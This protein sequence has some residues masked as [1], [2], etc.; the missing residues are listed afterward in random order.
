[1]KAEGV[2]NTPYFRA[3][4][5]LGAQLTTEDEVAGVRFSVWAP[6]ANRVELFGDFNDWT[7]GVHDLHCLGDSGIWSLFIPGLGEG[8]LYK[9]VIHGSNGYIEEKSDPMAFATELRPRTASKVWDIHKYVWDDAEWMHDRRHYNWLNEPISVYE[10]HPGSWKR[11]PEDGDRPL[12]Y[13]ELADDLIPY[14]KEMGFTHIELMPI[15]EHPFDGSWGYQC[16]GYFAPTSRFGTP[17]DFKAF[18]DACHQASIGVIIDWVP[19]HFPKDVHG[20]ADFDGTQLYEHADPR[21]GEHM[22]WGTLIF[23][24]GRD[25][26]KNF[27]YSSAMIWAEIYHIDGLRV[28]AVASMLYLDYSREHGQWEPNIYGGRENLEAIDFLKHFNELM[29]REF[30]GLMTFAEESTSFPGVSRPTYTGGLGF[31]L[32]WNMGWMNDTLSYIEHESIHRRYH[33]NQLTFSLIYAFNEN[34]ILPFSHDEVVH[35]KGSMLAKMPGDRW[36]QFANLR[37]LYA[38]MFLHPGKKLLFMGCE[39][40]QWTEWNHDRSLDWHVL[41]GEEHAKLRDMVSSLNHMYI[42]EGALHELDFDANGFYWLDH[43]DNDN[44][45]ISFVRKAI[46]QDDYLICVLNMTPI[47]RVDY[48]IALP[49]A[50]GYQVVFNSDDGQ[51][52]GSH[53]GQRDPVYAEERP[54]HRQ[55]Y[56]AD[57]SLPPLGAIVLR[58]G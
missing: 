41:I 53:N 32:K 18:V 33:H 6:N 50:G 20:L 35:G 21:K 55:E 49:D 10:I 4:Q 45:V 5:G 1:M 26:V 22:D 52:G 13:L 25:E 39:F 12:T 14:I 30:P 7:K 36:Q 57:V 42:K 31:S 37:L 2:L 38:Y 28:D 40:G 15:S 51:W 9:Y 54:W 27:L 24:F 44:S 46:D 19:A 48:R 56:S 16:L 43:H 34:F 23:N 29:H 58:R 11:I 8:T 17:D 3:Y 47:K